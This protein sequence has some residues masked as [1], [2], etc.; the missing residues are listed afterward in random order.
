MTVLQQ[1]SPVFDYISQS[2]TSTVFAY[3]GDDEQ[4]VIWSSAWWLPLCRYPDWCVFFCTQR[5]MTSQ[6]ARQLLVYLKQQLPSKVEWVPLN[7]TQS[8]NS[9]T[10]HII[11]DVFGSS[12]HWL[13]LSKH[14]KIIIIIIIKEGCWSQ[15]LG[16]LLRKQAMAY[17]DSRPNERG[18]TQQSPTSTLT[19]NQLAYQ[20]FKISN[21]KGTILRGVD[22]MS[23]P[24]QRRAV[25]KT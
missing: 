14:I 19:K 9:Y 7:S 4:Q 20:C 5:E 21:T 11:I 10:Q 6:P 24:W 8:L 16:S 12:R 17:Y 2:D 15:M 1:V 23:W 25:L 13:Y 22:T 3:W 18:Y